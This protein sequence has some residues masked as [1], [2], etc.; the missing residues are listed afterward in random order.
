MTIAA[1]DFDGTLT[2]RDSLWAFLRYYRGNWGFLWRIMLLSP[3]IIAYMLKI[4]PAHRVKGKVLSLFLKGESSEKIFQKG[5]AFCQELL[6]GMLDQKGMDKLFWHKTQGHRC[7]LITA[8]LDFW[9]KSFA[10]TQGLTLIATRGEIQDGTFT[11][12]IQGKNCKG[13]EKVKR[14]LA[15]LPSGDIKASYAYGN[16]AGDKE[17]L[18]WADNAF[19]KRFY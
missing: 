7:Y 17:L 8:S 2:K 14:L 15:E 16:S 13:K 19:Y 18:E 1:F 4:S 5:A 10:Q 12:K 11:G 6:P 3:W 9:T